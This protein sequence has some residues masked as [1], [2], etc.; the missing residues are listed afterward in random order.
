MKHVGKMKNNSARVAIAFRTLPGDVHS[1]LVVGTT[2]LPDIYHDNLMS[3]LESDSGQQ[4]SELADV[5]AVRKFPDGNNILEWLH[6]NG[7]L[8]KVPTKNVVVT[9]DTK[10]MLPLDELNKI[11]AEQKG[12][13]SVEDLNPAPVTN[14]PS[15]KE[16]AASAY[17]G[18]TVVTEE[19]KTPAKGTG[20]GFDFTP[21]ELRQMA[22]DHAK[23]AETLRAQA[24][25]LENPPAEK[26]KKRLAR[27][28][29]S[30]NLVS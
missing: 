4:A 3:V 14:N 22:D 1:A 5:L 17:T 12:L 29:R 8:K 27:P 21:D 2:G 19:K 9:P 10:T 16:N 25:A 13:S 23:K 30:R 24:D 6:L 18:K 7:H 11:I 15:D 26:P 28:N 20:T